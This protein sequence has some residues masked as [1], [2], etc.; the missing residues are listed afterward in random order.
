VITAFLSVLLIAD[1]LSN[2]A[3]SVD[4]ITRIVAGV[5]MVL[6]AVVVGALSVFPAQIA[7][8]S[9]ARRTPR[10]SAPEGDHRAERAGHPRTGAHPGIRRATTI[11]DPSRCSDDRICRQASNALR[12]T[13]SDRGR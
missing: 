12:R 7:G 2:G 1:G 8:S 10:R 6:I 13:G 9:E 3:G 5:L 4:G 11:E